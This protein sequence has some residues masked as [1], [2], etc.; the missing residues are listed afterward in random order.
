M[1][2]CRGTTASRRF[3]LLIIAIAAVFAMIGALGAPSPAQA[4][5]LTVIGHTGNP[6]GQHPDVS[7]AVG[8]SL[9]GDRTVKYVWTY[10]QLWPQVGTMKLDDSVNAS[11][12]LVITAV[13]GETDPNNRVMG[14]S[15]GSVD[16]GEAYNYFLAH[17]DEVPAG[18]TLS[19]VFLASPVTPNG[20]ILSRIQGITIPYFGISGRAPTMD[21]QYQVVDSHWAYE[22]FSSAPLYLLGPS[23]GLAWL[24][25][26]FGVYRTDAS[27][28]HGIDPDYTNP[29]Y[30]VHTTVVGNT[31]YH[32]IVPEHLP[33]YQPL[34]DHG[35]G[36]LVS[37]IE[38]LTKVWVDAA[39]Y[40]ND[41][42]ADPGTYHPLQLFMPIDNVIRASLQ[43]PGA[44]IKGL[45]ALPKAIESVLKPI[46]KP[47]PTTTPPVTTQDQEKSSSQAPVSAS[48]NAATTTE[49]PKAQHQ[50]K[51][52]VAEM[53]KPQDDPATPK[54]SAMS[55]VKVV[56]DPAE[57]QVT[58]PEPT[59]VP[60]N[61]GAS[62][63][64]GTDSSKTPE[65]KQ[66]KSGT[67]KDTKP[68]RKAPSAPKSSKS[69]TGSP[70]RGPS[71]TKSDTQG[72]HAV[73]KPN[74]RAPH[75]AG[76]HGSSGD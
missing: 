22:L 34:V 10:Q 31:T 56:H 32:V 27:S 23:T 20:G 7:K 51:P 57:S 43:T 63:S 62:D 16:V 66:P 17:P 15:Q 3:A 45:A 8:G 70:D 5:V 71:A 65:A 48:V 25:S 58:K 2:A 67:N 60:V 12:P 75:S 33:M 64:T 30:D 59:S 42:T 68:V 44:I 26:F 40:K 6:T 41:P 49:K 52:V 35:Y 38:P 47:A 53:A 73:T 24:N 72:R 37:V 19:F 61:S 1:N 39:Y 76:S 9:I 55:P 54:Q 36:A 18:T 69:A 29:N 50:P 4:D 14:E 46:A 11:I 28:L 21:S 13:K 74:R